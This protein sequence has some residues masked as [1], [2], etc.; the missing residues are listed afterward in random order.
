MLNLD[1]LELN[2][3]QSCTYFMW[4]NIFSTINLLRILNKLTK[5]KHARTMMLVVFKSA[6]ILKRSLRVRQALFQLYCLKLL[7]MQAKYLGRQWRRSNM[8]IMSSIYSKV[9]HRLNDDWAYGNETR[10]KPWDFQSEESALKCAV[11]KFN[12]RRYGDMFPSLATSSEEASLPT[13]AYNDADFVPL[14]N[15][16]LS[17]LGVHYEFTDR[18]KINYEQWVEREVYR[19]TVDWDL[20][21]NANR[22]VAG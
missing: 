3:A 22:G 13:A 15:N 16:V 20:L 18:F 19:S 11:E 17:V 21:L 8:E 9:R 12:A 5:W 4:R 10:S 6:P 14:D 1:N 7:K 2:D